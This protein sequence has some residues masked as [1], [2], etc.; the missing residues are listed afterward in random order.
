PAAMR[1]EHLTVEVVVQAQ[2]QLEALSSVSG[3]VDD[4]LPLVVLA[5]AIDV[6]PV[7]HVVAHLAVVADRAEKPSLG[8]VRARPQLQVN[9]LPRLEVPNPVGRDTAV[10]GAIA[11]A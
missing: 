2:C 8:R 1:L 3:E 10:C 4:L 6:T 11:F 9:G 7:L 5:P